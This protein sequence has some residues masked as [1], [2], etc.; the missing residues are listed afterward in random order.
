[1]FFL[2]GSADKC[3]FPDS[4]CVLLVVADYFSICAVV[5]GVQRL[6]L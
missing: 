4:L 5:I 1:M 3:D 2:V 6:L